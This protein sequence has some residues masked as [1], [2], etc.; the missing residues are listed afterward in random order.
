MPLHSPPS[1]TT[2]LQLLNDTSAPPQTPDLLWRINECYQVQ[3]NQF[4]KLCITGK[5]Q[6][7]LNCLSHSHL[8]D[9]QTQLSSRPIMLRA[10]LSL[11]EEQLPGWAAAPSSGP[12]T[13]APLPGVSSLQ[14]WLSSLPLLFFNLYQSHPLSFVI[15]TSYHPSPPVL[16]PCTAAAIQPS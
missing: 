12:R 4:I 8:I 13:K 14:P 1:S 5:W 6:P 3:I 11:P 2:C 16:Q 7:N 15:F 9:L 10:A